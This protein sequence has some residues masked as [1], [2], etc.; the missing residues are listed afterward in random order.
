[1]ARLEGYR[2][3]GAGRGQVGKAPGPRSGKMAQGEKPGG[4]TDRHPEGDSKDDRCTVTWC[5]LAGASRH[6]KVPHNAT[7]A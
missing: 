7:V 5:A 3:R 1:M 4:G 2:A 6:I